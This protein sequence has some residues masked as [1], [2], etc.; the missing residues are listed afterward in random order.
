[1]RVFHGKDDFVD[2]TFQ[3]LGP[4]ELKK[5]FNLYEVVPGPSETQ[6]EFLRFL[7][8]EVPDNASMAT[9]YELIRM[10]PKA[11]IQ[12]F[13]EYESMME[14]VC[15]SG[16]FETYDIEVLDRETILSVINQMMS[17]GASFEHIVKNSEELVERLVEGG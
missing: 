16:F 5:E 15:D 10:N 1:M 11:S 9:V 4:K 12:L 8:I 6:L 17:E 2:V 13:N 3:I 14:E 7:D